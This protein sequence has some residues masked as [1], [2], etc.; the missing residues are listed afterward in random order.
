MREGQARVNYRISGGALLFRPLHRK[1]HS[2]WPVSYPLCCLS[3]VINI[4]QLLPPPQYMTTPS[5]RRWPSRQ[6]R[7]SQPSSRMAPPYRS[8]FD[9][10]YESRDRNRDRDRGYSREYDN[11]DRDTNRGYYRRDERD[12]RDYGERDDRDRRDRDDRRRSAGKPR[13]ITQS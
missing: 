7:E 9:R 4:E 11:R 8:R 2:T 12:R 5:D 6:E 10:P 1:V 3:S 13:Q